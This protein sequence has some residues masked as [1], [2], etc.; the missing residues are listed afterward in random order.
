MARL[1]F[2]EV[3]RVMWGLQRMKSASPEAE[4]EI[5]KLI[6]YSQR[7]MPI[8]LTIDP[9]NRGSIGEAQGALNRPINSF[10]MCG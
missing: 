7:T 10:A 6:G 5:R 4:E 9:S 8:V 3:E 2:A 1:N